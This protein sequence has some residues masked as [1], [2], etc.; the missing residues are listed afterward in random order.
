MFRRGHALMV[1]AL[2]TAILSAPAQAA[3]RSFVASFGNDAN[4]ASNCGFANPCRGFTAALGVT[5]PG[6]EI[7]ALDAAGYGAV[8]INKSVTI[9]ANPGFYA[10]ISAASGS[11]VTIATAGVNV[12]LRGLNINGIGAASGVL[13]SNGSRLSIENCV[14]SNFQGPGI[15]VSGTTAVVRVVDSLF[16]ENNDGVYVQDGPNVTISGSKFLG[17]GTH[18]LFVISTTATATTVAAVSDSVF[19]GN[20]VAM[21]VRA[22]A[23]GGVGRLSASNSTMVNNT[24]GFAVDGSVGTQI[25]TISNSTS[26]GNQYG[27]YNFGGTLESLGNNSVRQNSGANTVGT[28]TIVAGN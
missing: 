24:Y 16:R 9:T 2:S 10:G 26:T 6:G 20:F 3:Q 22:Q 27:L 1:F 19:S 12:T 18:A 23:V 15:Q 5:D 8:T 11:A 7:V 28:I 21:E 17:H 4:T 14:I 13:M 25:G